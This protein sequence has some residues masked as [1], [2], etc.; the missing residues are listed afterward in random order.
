MARLP[1]AKKSCARS[2]SKRLQAW[3]AR[4]GVA[5]ALFARLAFLRTDAGISIVEL[6]IDHPSSVAFCTIQ[7]HGQIDQQVF[8]LLV[9]QVIL[10]I[11]LPRLA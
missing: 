5:N 1:S 4:V 3:R 11:W 9:G 8:E 10:L 2:S 6:V 7:Y